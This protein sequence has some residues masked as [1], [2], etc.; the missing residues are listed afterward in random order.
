MAGKG[1]ELA[2][3]Y[4]TLI[5]SL[6]GAEKAIEKELAGIDV[7]N[8][9][10]KMGKKLGE[11]A[12]KAAGDDASDGIEKGVEKTDTVPHFREGNSQISRDCTFTDTPFRG[13]DG[14][15]SA[16]FAIAAEDGAFMRL[17]WLFIRVLFDKDVYVTRIFGM[18]GDDQL[19]ATFFEGCG[20][21]IPVPVE[22]KGKLNLVRG[23]RRI[24]NH[25]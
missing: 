4:I 9:G 21:R 23:D 19:L 13:T 16:R 15:D 6:R 12:G 2:N 17:G 24:F 25:A 7:T 8:S 22:N 3:A 5:P 14:Y 20:E 1:T 10:K 11:A 18:T